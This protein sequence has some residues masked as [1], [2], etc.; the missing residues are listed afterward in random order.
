MTDAPPIHYIA[1]SALPAFLAA[2]G[3][4][5]TER[6]A[7]SIATSRKLPFF[8]NPV[9]PGLVTTA[10]LVDEALAKAAD[11]ARR[12]SR[13]EGVKPTRRPVPSRR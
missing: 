8:R 10:A 11:E 7:R 12:E 6:Q 3:I 1:V 4:R 2:R 9:G 13:R 5:I